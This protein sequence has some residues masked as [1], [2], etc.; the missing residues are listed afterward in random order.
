MLR[1][2]HRKPGMAMGP[3]R[4]RKIDRIYHAALEIESSQ[5]GKLLKEDCRADESLREEVEQLLA[6]DSQT[7]GFSDLPAAG[8]PPHSLAPTGTMA[9]TTASSAASLAGQTVSHFRV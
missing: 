5:R 1:F 9:T 8:M 4:W 7:E 3:E 6:F 2:T